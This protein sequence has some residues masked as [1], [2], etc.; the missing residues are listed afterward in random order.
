MLALT[1]L[2]LGAAALCLFLGLRGRV[3]TRELHCKSCGYDLTGIERTPHTH[4]PE[5]G[6][7]V[8]VRTTYRVHRV[9]SRLWLRW[10]LACGALAM[11]P[12]ALVALD[13]HASLN[14]QRLQS[15]ERLKQMIQQT[16]GA[17]IQRPAWAELLRRQRV[18][19]LSEDDIAEI[20]AIALDAHL[21]MVANANTAVSAAKQRGPQAMRPA[22]ALPHAQWI[23][24][25]WK[26]RLA[27]IES[28]QAYVETLFGPAT[29]FKVPANVVQGGQLQVTLIVD[30]RGRGGFESVEVV[31]RLEGMTMDDQPYEAAE[32]VA[33]VNRLAF[34]EPGGSPNRARFAVPIDL[35]AGAHHMRM[36]LR[37]GITQMT[38]GRGESQVVLGRALTDVDIWPATL[39]EWTVEGGRIVNV[40]SSKE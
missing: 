24:L 4:C 25:A 2:L 38:I 35:P 8:W 27:P 23:E 10:A 15:V 3:V 31:V 14:R 19:V 34:A 21:M 36:T 9:P 11:L 1:W 13:K 7:N 32:W 22:L 28:I 33:L 12:A 39:C 18:G 17:N 16:T 5:C 30:S 26:T 29:S 40:T 37:A 20:T 6:H